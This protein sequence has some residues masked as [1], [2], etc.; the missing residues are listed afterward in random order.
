M[1]TSVSLTI[2]KP[3]TVWITTNWKILQEMGLPSHLICLLRNLYAVQEVT[4]RTGRGKTDWFQ[5]RKEYVKVVYCHPTY[6][7]YMESISAECQAG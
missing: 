3:L 5:M 4:T 6:L 7:S 2:I 1:S